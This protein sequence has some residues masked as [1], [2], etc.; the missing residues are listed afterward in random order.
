MQHSQGS[1]QSENSGDPGS[2]GAR[3]MQEGGTR[4]SVQGHR[5]SGVGGA[6]HMVQLRVVTASRQVGCGIQA[7]RSWTA[8]AYE[9]CTSCHTRKPW[10]KHCSIQPDA[11]PPATVMFAITSLV[12]Y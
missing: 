3:M 2:P 11:P 7:L 1:L 5:E 9:Y 10:S 12:Q 8:M 4:S 6:H